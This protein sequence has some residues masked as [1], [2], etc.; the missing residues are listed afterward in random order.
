ML[1]SPF[2]AKTG[3]VRFFIVCLTLSLTAC[4]WH[5]ENTHSQEL[6]GHTVSDAALRLGP[7]T[8]KFDLGNGRMA[9]DWEH[10][11]PCTYSAI[12]TS[13]KP[14]SPCWPTGLSKA[15]GRQRI[16][17]LQDEQLRFKFEVQAHPGG[18]A[19]ER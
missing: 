11:G 3:M 17:R 2:G 19:K 8:S 7:P 18:V 15:G 1:F 5:T 13:S 16:A 10:Y 14:A 4:T 9:F 12:A 6:V